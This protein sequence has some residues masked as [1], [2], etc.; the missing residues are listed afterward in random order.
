MKSAPENPVAGKKEKEIRLQS[1]INLKKKYLTDL[2]TDLSRNY[3]FTENLL[4]KVKK[5]KRSSKK[6]EGIKDMFVF[7]SKHQTP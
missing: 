2:T 5:L 6:E 1:E 3:E 7:I 4:S